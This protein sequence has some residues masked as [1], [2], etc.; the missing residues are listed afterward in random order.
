[1]KKIFCLVLLLL[2]VPKLYAQTS[3]YKFHSVFIYNFTKYIQWPPAQQSGDFIIGV[4]GTSPAFDELQ[5]ITGN[6]LVGTQ[7]IVVK[8]FKSADEI[9][10][11]HILFVP[12]SSNFESAQSKL[13]GKSTL[14]VTEK[15]GLAMKGSSINFVLQDNKWKFELNESTMQGS[16]L[17]VSKELTKLAILV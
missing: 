8:R 10:D 15:S 1:M 4:L 2:V 13:K 5:K 16:G 3:D 9:Q 12:S 17:K 6:K 11:C 7:K 14:I